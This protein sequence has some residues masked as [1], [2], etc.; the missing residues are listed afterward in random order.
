MQYVF[1]HNFRG[2]TDTLLLLKNINFLVGENS[3]GKSSF[4]KLLYVLSRANF[5]LRPNAPFPDEAELGGFGDM[6]SARSPDKSYFQVGAM[7]VGKAKNTSKLSCSFSVHTFG[8]RD[9]SP[10]VSRYMEFSE[11][12]LTKLTFQK[13]RMKYKINPLP[14]DFATPSDVVKFFESVVRSDRDDS[15]GFS[16]FPKHIPP[17]TPLPIAVAILRSMDK[18]KPMTGG[19]FAFGIPFPLNL[20]WIAPIRTRPQRF[21]DAMRKPFSPEG[22]HTPFMLRRSLRATSKSNGFAEKLD[23]F[24]K[25][26]GLFETIIPHSFGKSPRSPFEILVR[27]SGANLN[28]SNVGYGVSQVLPL[29]VEFLSDD[30]KSAFV[31]QQ[32]EVH[33]HP[34]AQAALGDLIAEVAAERDHNFMLETHS[35]YLIDRCRLN[36]SKRDD[37]VQAQTIFFQQTARGN[38]ATVLLIGKDGKYPHDQP[39]EFRS[40]FI[41]EEMDLLEV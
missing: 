35:E 8:N 19:E 33:L 4:L 29:V 32:P 40:F 30:E 14:N 3:T 36:L 31:V 34:R 21:Y 15:D 26:S 28:V 11:G 9:G 6:V 27:F 16:L 22:D 38:M 17:D 10:Y 7:S 12:H 2:F 1:M 5:W 18:G 24:G 20:T 37:P 23:A 13:S 25:E 39:Q 41:K